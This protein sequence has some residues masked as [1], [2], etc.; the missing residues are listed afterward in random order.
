[1]IKTSNSL[2]TGRRKKSKTWRVREMFK[3]VEGRTIKW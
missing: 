2:D 1:M 3:G